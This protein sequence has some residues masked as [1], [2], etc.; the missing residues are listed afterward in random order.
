M[1]KTS[2]KSGGGKSGGG[3]SGAADKTSKVVAPAPKVA[4]ALLSTA[5][6]KDAWEESALD[7]NEYARFVTRN[8]EAG[9]DTSDIDTNPNSLDADAELSEGDGETSSPNGDELS[10]DELSEDELSEDELSEDELSEDELSEDELSEEE[11]VSE[12]ELSEEEIV[13]EEEVSSEDEIAP[14]GGDWTLESSE[15]DWVDLSDSD[16]AAE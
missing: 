5:D 7:D 8:E 16:P 11:V 14:D 9:E 3:K 15:S 2:G 12:D 6:E 1:A 4:E 13:S 10:E